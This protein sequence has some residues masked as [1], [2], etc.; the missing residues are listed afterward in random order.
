MQYSHRVNVS[1]TESLSKTETE[2]PSGP[3]EMSERCE[4]RELMG[5]AAGGAVP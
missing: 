5:K 4:G 3:K 1:K 2:K